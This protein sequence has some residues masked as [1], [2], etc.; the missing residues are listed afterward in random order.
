M[1][2]RMKRPTV[3]PADR[4]EVYQAMEDANPYPAQYR[5]CP[6]CRVKL[7]EKCISLSGK[8]VNGRPDQVRTELDKPHVMRK[9]R[10][11]K[12]RVV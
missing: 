4:D 5:A 11:R 3:A 9:R 8:V 2:A 6:V 10:T 12:G 7:G 1:T